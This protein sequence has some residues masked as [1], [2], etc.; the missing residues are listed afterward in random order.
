MLAGGRIVSLALTG[1]RLSYPTAREPELAVVFRDISQEDLVHRLLGHFISN[2]V[3]E[4]RT[5]LAAL[6]ASLE[7]LL[8]KED[9]SRPAERHKLLKGLQVSVVNLQTLVDN[10]LESA[11]FEAGH[12]RVSPRPFDLSDL[13]TVAVRIM[14]PLLEKYNQQLLVKLPAFLPLVQADPRRMVQV[15]VNLLSNASKYGP[16]NLEIILSASVE[17][18]FVRVK[19]DDRGPGISPEQRATLFRRFAYPETRHENLRMGAGLGLSVVKAIVEAHG[20]Q[21]GVDNPST[22]GTTFWFTL[23]IATEI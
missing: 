14:Q 6:N 18:G 7:L 22:G 20:G 13:I 12:F 19:V 4:F 9:T 5:P 10:L 16:A 15:L 11:S 1:A 2:V 23:P 8:D 3:H 17:N 21:T